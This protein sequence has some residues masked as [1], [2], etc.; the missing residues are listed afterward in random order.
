MGIFAP[1]RLFFFAGPPS[2]R[3][4][5]DK[6][7]LHPG[8]LPVGLDSADLPGVQPHE[9]AELGLREAETVAEF[10]EFFRCHLSTLV[11]VWLYRPLF[12][13]TYTPSVY[14]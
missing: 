4:V 12:N 1:A 13:Y 9:A 6:S 11:I 8:R 14:S 2:G 5:L 7:R 10:A 3:D